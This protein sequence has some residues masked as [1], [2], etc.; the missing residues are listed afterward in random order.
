M[1]KIGPPST[2]RR[3][4]Y[5]GNPVA[6]LVEAISSESRLALDIREWGRHAPVHGFS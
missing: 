5:A 1:G 3:G 6:V 4:S 2:E